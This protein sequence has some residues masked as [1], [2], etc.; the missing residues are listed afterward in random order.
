MA[1]GGRGWPGPTYPGHAELSFTQQ[2]APSRRPHICAGKYVGVVNELFQRMQLRTV[3][4]P[5]LATAPAVPPDEAVTDLQGAL[6]AP[7]AAPRPVGAAPVRHAAR[8]LEA[9]QQ[10]RRI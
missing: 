6:L 10:P 2:Y 9:V 8:D 4:I 7:D 3:S 5:L 1:L